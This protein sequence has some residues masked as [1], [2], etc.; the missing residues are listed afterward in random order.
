MIILPFSNFFP[1]QLK[2]I[3]KKIY[4]MVTQTAFLHHSNLQ[5]LLVLPSHPP[6]SPKS[7]FSMSLLSLNTHTHTRLFTTL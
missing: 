6:N 2:K 7:S 4:T 3:K 1:S 5:T